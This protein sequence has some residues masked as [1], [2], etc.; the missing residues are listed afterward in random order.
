MRESPPFSGYEQHDRGT[1]ETVKVLPLLLAVLV[2]V[3]AS[4]GSAA[5][6]GLRGIVMRGPITPVCAA[7]SLCD[8]PAKHISIVFVRKGVS[9]K[10]T[11]DATGRYRIAL[12]PGAYAVRIPTGRFGY[13]PRSA[14][15]PVGR[16]AV[17]NFSIDTGIR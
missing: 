8:A 12:A 7:E 10:A 3:L 17:R 4:A 9:H 13:S 6:S 14:V 15:V 5:T 1:I 11:T 16:V 2:L